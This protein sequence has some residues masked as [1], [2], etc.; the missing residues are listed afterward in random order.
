[1]QLQNDVNCMNYSFVHLHP[2]SEPKSM[3]WVKTPKK[4]EMGTFCDFSA[5]S[6]LSQP[7]KIS[8]ASGIEQQNIRQ[9]I[10]QNRCKFK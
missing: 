7:S 1:M 6:Q 8:W 3:K 5:R 9:L 4:Y 10:F 2:H